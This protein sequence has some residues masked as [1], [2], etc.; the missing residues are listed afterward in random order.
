MWK[1]TSKRDY[2]DVDSTTDRIVGVFDVL[3]FRNS[4][5]TIGT[6]KLVRA[7]AAAIGKAQAILQQTV[8]E[9]LW[10]VPAE[11]VE[12]EGF[13]GSSNS[14]AEPRLVQASLFPGVEEIVV[15]SDSVFIFGMDDSPDVLRNVLRSSVALFRVF[16][17]SGLPLAG[18]IAKG[19]AV[20]DH[21]LEI[22]AG[23]GIVS[24]YELANSVDIVGVV[25]HPNIPKLEGV[26]SEAIKIPRKHDKS[27]RIQS[28]L[29]LMVPVAPAND[30][31]L[32]QITAPWKGIVKRQIK[33]VGKERKV[34]AKWKHSAKVLSS[35][36]NAKI[37]I[38]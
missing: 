31:Q 26:M 10:H 21:R 5:K 22:Y 30:P 27:C 7:Y 29:K 14:F 1:M 16:L 33:N 15:F 13:P 18:A 4:L 34:L 11:Y 35:I 36:L 28:P 3:G 12:D 9:V 24:A 2:S 32:T 6:N 17:Q 23:S 38:P 25:V 8:P 20:V 37:A 19:D